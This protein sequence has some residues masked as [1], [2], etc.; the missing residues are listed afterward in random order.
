VSPYLARPY[1]LELLLDICANIAK[2]CGLFTPVDDGA[3][4][5]T[6]EKTLGELLAEFAK[7]QPSSK[8]LVVIEALNQLDSTTASR[9]HELSWVPSSLP[10]NVRMILSTLPNSQPAKVLEGRK[11]PSAAV[12]GLS[13]HDRSEIVTEILSKYNKRL[14][15]SQMKHLLSKADALKPLF[16]S[17]A[18]EELRVFGI[19]E[20]LTQKIRDMPAQLYEL[21][22]SMVRRVESDHGSSVSDMLSLL[23]LSKSGL[24]ETELAELLGLNASHLTSLLLAL[25]IFTRRVGEEQSLDFAHRQFA[26]ASAKMFFEATAGPATKSKYQKQLA[27]FYLTKYKQSQAHHPSK[28]AE[29]EP[30]AVSHVLHYCISAGL[31]AETEQLLTSMR[32]L[33]RRCHLGQVYELVADLQAAL[34]TFSGTWTPQQ[35]SRVQRFSSFIQSNVYL[36]AGQPELLLQQALNSA[37]AIRQAGEV[38]LRASTSAGVAEKFI[39][40]INNVNDG[41]DTASSVLLV[42]MDAKTDVNDVCWSPNDGGQTLL[43]SHRDGSISVWNRRTGEELSRMS[44]AHSDR[45]NSIEFV[46]P[47]GQ[48]FA[49]AAADKSVLGLDCV[50]VGSMF[51]FATGCEDGAIRVYHGSNPNNLTVQTLPDAHAAGAT[52]IRLDFDTTN[53]YLASGGVNKQ[54]KLWKTPVA[55]VKFSPTSN[56]SSAHTKPVKEVK[57]FVWN[58]KRYVLSSSQDKTIKVWN[59]DSGSCVCNIDVHGDNVETCDVAIRSGK[60]HIVSGSWDRSVRVFALDATLARA[61]QIASL[62]SISHFVNAVAFSPDNANTILVGSPDHTARIF[63]T[64]AAISASSSKGSASNASKP[65]FNVHDKMIRGLAYDPASNLLATGSWDNTACIMKVSGSGAQ[66]KLEKMKTITGHTKRVN[67][68]TWAA[69]KQAGHSPTLVTSSMDQLVRTWNADSG[70]PLKTFK[71]HKSNV[72]VVATSHDGRYIASASSDTKIMIWNNEGGKSSSRDEAIATLDAHSDWA[73]AITFSPMS[74]RLVTAS[75]DAQIKVWNSE[76]GEEIETLRGHEA[77]VLQVVYSHDGKLIASAS[78]DRTVRLWD[79]FTL[80]CVAV[81]R[82]HAHELTSCHFLRGP[83]GHILV[84]GSSDKTIRFWNCQTQSC[85]WTYFCDSGV[86]SIDSSADGSVIFV[87][88]SAGNVHVL[89]LSAMSWV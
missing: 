78:E 58:S 11:T 46:R 35:V 19:F 12:G 52:C 76:T 71:G 16:L 22:Q 41:D 1:S 82:G 47:Q 59:W 84:T 20:K 9:V 14:D 74:R 64:D 80:N 38:E 4:F 18:C 27:Q 83:N 72:F 32:Y 87:G 56:L 39:R 8:L 62:P 33:R 88:E 66:T 63:S 44:G 69:P 40:W 24:L 2:T 50:Q 81:M 86:T 15:D 3:D 42:A 5:D 57:L 31:A 13:E 68:V 55:A 17:A 6:L 43:S 29:P 23:F 7:A 51:V 21:I 45:I 75:R 34:K 89:D 49:S 36:F 28:G 26:K 67:I 10:K 53:L 54:I 65:L 30:R 48:Y 79:A 73:T 25:E 77:C 60:V 61:E 85:V 70:A 37:G